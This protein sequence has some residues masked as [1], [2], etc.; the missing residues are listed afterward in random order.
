MVVKQD[1][2][3]CGKYLVT[4]NSEEND[5]LAKEI[6]EE[7]EPSGAAPKYKLHPL[8]VTIVFAL[9]LLSLSILK[10]LSLYFPLP[11]PPPLSVLLLYHNRG[12]STENARRSGGEE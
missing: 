3:I 7:R 9:V 12:S 1:L 5:K 8:I 10:S 11:T 6:D 4:I 2:D